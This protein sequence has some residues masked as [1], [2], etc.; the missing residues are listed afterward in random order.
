[1]RISKT[2]IRKTT[3]GR[4]LAAAPTARPTA[5][6]RARPRPAAGVRE[7]CQPLE[8][9]RLLSAAVTAVMGTDGVI[10]VTGTGHGDEIAIVQHA[11]GA[12]AYDVLANGAV[13][14]QFAASSAIRVEARGG[15]DVVS[16][17][18]GITL[19]ATVVG[20]VGNDQIT[21]G[22][23]DDSLDGGGDRDRLT[24]GAGNDTLSGGQGQDGLHGGDGNDTLEGGKGRDGLAGDAGDDAISGGAGNDAIDGGDGN[25]TLSGGRQ[26]DMISGGPGADRF[27]KDE[28]DNEILDLSP[29]DSRS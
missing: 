28:Q 5:R 6:R 21:G 16:V 7:W 17:A 14:G 13:V 12:Q 11:P 4:R 29:E 23:G 22:A 10:V 2:C 15:D 9:R 20:G 8:P 1:M 24:G 18:D 19:P 26:R 27:V 25:D 3:A